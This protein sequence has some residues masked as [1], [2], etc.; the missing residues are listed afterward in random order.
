MKI[1]LTTLLLALLAPVAATSHQDQSA[2]TTPPRTAIDS[3]CADFDKFVEYLEETH[4][5][6]YTAFGGR[7]LFYQKVSRIRESLRDDSVTDRNGL[8][9]NISEFIACLH[10]GHTLVKGNVIEGTP[11]YLPLRFRHVADAL[12]IKEA[13]DSL[14]RLIGGKVLSAAGVALDELM[15]RMSRIRTSE[16]NS[17]SLENLRYHLNDERYLKRLTGISTDSVVMEIGLSDGS[18]ERIKVPFLSY[19]EVMG[20]Q[21]SAPERKLSLP[22]GNMDYC[23]LDHGR[24]AYFRLKSMNSRDNFD[25]MRK[26]GMDFTQQLKY[27]YRTE[28]L[29]MT[30]DPDKDIDAIPVAVDAF[31]TLL[32]EMAAKK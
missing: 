20:V 5:D 30:G 23:F 8:A 12:L 24:T 3:V 18:I 10:D 7:L 1:Y 28:G 11:R 19:E 4:P 6:P 21:Y 17:G 9:K 26:Q 2:E 22:K 31:G 27:Y 14:R 15:E 29:K 16:N 13:S 25:F 32:G